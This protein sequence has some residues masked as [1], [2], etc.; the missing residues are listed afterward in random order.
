[1]RDPRAKSMAPGGRV[2]HVNLEP[3]ARH[4]GKGVDHRRRDGH[5][6]A[7]DAVPAGENGSAVVA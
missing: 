3:V 1:M 6:P 4:V 7:V 2:G 5:G